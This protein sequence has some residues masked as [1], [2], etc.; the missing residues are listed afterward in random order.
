VYGPVRS[1]LKPL[2]NVRVL[3]LD[4]DEDTRELFGV[5]LEEAGADV[6]A[7][8]DAQEAV[9]VAL[10]WA[11]TIVVSDLS[12]P[13]T[14]GITFLRELRAMPG[15]QAVP[16]IAVTGWSGEKDRT[17]VLAAGFQEHVAK[18]VN[19][20]QLVAAVGRWA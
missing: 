15:L 8:V 17:A 7:A 11:P 10:H 18:P 13:T 16:A 12:M 1:M 14:D 5:T 4:D 2:A 19:A 20:E 6:R 9:R 3:L